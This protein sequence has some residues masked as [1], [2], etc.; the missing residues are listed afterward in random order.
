MKT[1]TKCNKSKPESEFQKQSASRDGLKAFCKTCSKL[2]NKLRYDSLSEKIGQQVREWQL[3]NPE[4]V[5]AA[6]TKF[7]N[8]NK[9]A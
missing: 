9:K 4:K 2:L 6:K 7:R 5:S 1:C 8:K 3:K